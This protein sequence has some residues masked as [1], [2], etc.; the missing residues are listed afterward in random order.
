MCVFFQSEYSVEMIFFNKARS[1]IFFYLLKRSDGY[2]LIMWKIISVVL[3][4][5]FIS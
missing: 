5:D 2:I 4:K 3:L 1:H